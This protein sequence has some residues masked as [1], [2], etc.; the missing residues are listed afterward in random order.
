M[1]QA[2]ESRENSDQ[3]VIV[4]ISLCPQSAG[5]LPTL[6]STTKTVG[7][8]CSFGAPSPVAA[9]SL[10]RDTGIPMGLVTDHSCSHLEPGGLL[11]LTPGVWTRGL[12]SL[13][14]LSRAA[15]ASRC[16]G[17]KSRGGAF[18]ERLSARDGS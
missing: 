13:S 16:G 6:A 14:P 8:L 12:G 4:H 1:L 15:N 9:F 17:G 18:G 11:Q 10:S 2:L 3:R 7:F 5:F